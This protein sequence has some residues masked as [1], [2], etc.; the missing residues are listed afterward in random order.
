MSRL[1]PC[2]SLSSIKISRGD[3]PAYGYSASVTVH[4]DSMHDS[5]R[6]SDALLISDT[7]VVHYAVKFSQTHNADNP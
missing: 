4:I 1:T 2:A 3:L 6:R 5:A 7:L